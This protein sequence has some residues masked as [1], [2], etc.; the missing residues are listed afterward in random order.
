M[1]K[2]TD[3]IVDIVRA[4]GSVV[5]DAGGRMNDQLVTIAQAAAVSGATVTI[6]NAGSK[7]TEQLVAIAQAGKGRVVFDLTT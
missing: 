3:H 6:R 2:L 1:A 7:V 4:G 5:I